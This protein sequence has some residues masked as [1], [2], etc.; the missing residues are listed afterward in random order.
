MKS[1]IFVSYILLCYLFDLSSASL[2]LP[3]RSSLAMTEAVTGNSDHRHNAHNT[4]D[5]HSAINVCNAFT[6]WSYCPGS[7]T[8][9]VHLSDFTI[10]V[11][12]PYIMSGWSFSLA[13]THTNMLV[14]VIGQQSVIGAYNNIQTADTMTVNAVSTFMANTSYYF[15]TRDLTIGLPSGTYQANQIW[16][17]P[18]GK[19][20]MCIEYAIKL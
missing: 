20:L 9:L 5:R 12:P 4:N 19:P 17:D 18:L 14:S 8:D 13:E 15:V 6:I 1:V 7:P 16:T 10:L 3:S 11:C 2:L